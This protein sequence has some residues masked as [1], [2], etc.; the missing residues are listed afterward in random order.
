VKNPTETIFVE[1]IQTP[2]LKLIPATLE[3]ARAELHDR[4]AFAQLLQATI[5]NNWPPESAADALPLF[6]EWLEAAPDKVGWFGWYAIDVAN[7][8]QP[9]L[10]GSGGFLGPPQNGEIHLGYSVLSQ[11]Q[12]K[13]F[14]T[15]MVRPLI[16]WA[17]HHP[18]LKRIAAET[19]WK[20]PASVRVLEKLGF[21]QNGPGAEPGGMRFVLDVR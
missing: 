10:I 5:P 18:D 4:P 16:H 19:E 11:F 1:P 14:A 17:Q 21:V 8:N 15:E 9:V 12:K 7:Q 2:R 13:G 6:L 20:N 3:H